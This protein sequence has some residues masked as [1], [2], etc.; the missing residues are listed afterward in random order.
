MEKVY[1]VSEFKRILAESSNEFK[2]KIGSGVES[3]EKKNNGKAYDDAKKRA[4]DYDGG[5]SDEVG[6]KKAEYKK[7]DFNR[8]TLDY[9]PDNATPE[10]KKRVH[11]QVDGYTSEAEKKNGIEKAGDFSDNDKI[12]KELKKS[13]EELQDNAKTMKKSGLQARE[14]PD[15]VFDK[16]SM[17]ESK[18]GFDMRRMLNHINEIEDSIKPVNEE[19]KVKTIAFKKT[20]FLN[21]EHM[22][23]KIPDDFKKEGTSFK[24]KDKNGNSYLIEWKNGKANI[25]EHSNKAGFNESMSRMKQLFDYKTNDTQTSYSDRLNENDDKFSDTLNKMR[26]IIK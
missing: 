8:T 21:E 6:E 26:R 9:T 15:E 23:N 7:E 13:G 4:K 17:Y 14:W 10:Y 2:A 12:Y 22:I 3:E 11:A 20:E 16:E 19:K 24:M 18:D 1:K 5:L 25:L